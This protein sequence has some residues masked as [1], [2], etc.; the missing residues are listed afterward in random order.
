MARGAT[1]RTSARI[2][3]VEL[4]A[5]ALSLLLTLLTVVVGMAKVQKLPASFSIRDAAQISPS[6]WTA[7]GWIELVAAG[8]LVVG[9]FAN[10]TTAM[11]AAAALGVSYLALAFRQL[12]AHQPIATLT[13]A[14]VLSGLAVATVVVVYLAGG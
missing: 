10:H 2:L 9:I 14:L 4:L 3:A 6:W 8:F 5:V 12:S 11:V 7:S 1:Q 13:P